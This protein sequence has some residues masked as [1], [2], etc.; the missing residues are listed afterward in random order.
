MI[1]ENLQSYK[2]STSIHSLLKRDFIHWRM[3]NQ[4]A[5]AEKQMNHFTNKSSDT[6]M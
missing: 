6:Q 5:V 1:S 3:N 4:D 2:T